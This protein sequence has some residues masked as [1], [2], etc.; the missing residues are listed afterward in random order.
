MQ[1][2][3]VKYWM[4]WKERRI[5]RRFQK[6]HQKH[7]QILKGGLCLTAYV[8]RVYGGRYFP[9]QQRLHHLKLHISVTDQTNIVV[10]AKCLQGSDKQ[11]QENRHI[12]LK[13]LP[14]DLSQVAVLSQLT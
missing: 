14:G 7:Q 4:N 9:G 10:V 3:L 11:I 1:L 2:P 5:N 12:Y 8:I 6:L 13:F